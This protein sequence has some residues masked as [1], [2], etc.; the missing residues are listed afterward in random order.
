MTNKYTV[1]VESLAADLA[2]C[3]RVADAAR[4]KWKQARA[5]HEEA[6][7]ELRQAIREREAARQRL[8]ERE[9]LAERI[10]Y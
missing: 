9:A 1:S 3:T 10:G 8:A 6:H 7:E 4:A 5:A 2:A